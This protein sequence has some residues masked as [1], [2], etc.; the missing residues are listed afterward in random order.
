[1]NP[2]P[3]RPLNPRVY[4][5]PFCIKN[6]LQL[7]MLYQY[8]KNTSWIKHLNWMKAKWLWVT[9]SQSS[10][11]FHHLLKCIFIQFFFSHF[12]LFFFAFSWPWYMNKKTGLVI[13]FLQNFAY[14]TKDWMFTKACK[15][16][17]LV[18]RL[19][20]IWVWNW[21]RIWIWN[22]LC[23]CR[24][25]KKNLSRPGTGDQQFHH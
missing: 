6:I 2:P 17:V 5:I 3:P 1:M 4:F 20:L 7:L 18:L 14:K 24:I 8:H 11:D 19:K 25:Y 21:R 16:R 23:N 15:I 12:T 22:E 10:N 13:Y 9:C